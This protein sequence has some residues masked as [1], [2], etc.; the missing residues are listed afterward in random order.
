MPHHNFYETLGLDRTKDAPALAKEIDSRLSAG[1]LSAAARDELQVARK[2]LGDG[3][4]RQV[5]DAKL[6]DPN[7][8]EIT[9]SALRELAAADFG[10]Q[11]GAQQWRDVGDTVQMGESK[12]VEIDSD[13]KRT[14]ESSPKKNKPK[15]YFPDTDPNAEAVTPHPYPQQAAQPAYPP[16]YPA[17]YPYPPQGYYPPPQQPFYPPQ[18]APA[19]P[20]KKKSGTSAALIVAIV[21]ALAGIG[22]GG[23]WLWDNHGTEWESNDQ[24]LA[25]AFPQIVSEK[26][27]QRG[28]FDMKCQSMPLEAGQKARIRCSNN[29]LGVS[30]MDYGSQGTRDTMLPD[31]D[32]SVIGN[33]TCKAK[34]Y[35]MQDVSPPAFK[36]APEGPDSRFLLVVNGNDAEAKRMYLNLCDKNRE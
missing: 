33:S 6:G 34:S 30:V 28:W 1:N 15:Q 19:E 24:V 29:E 12:T 17:P 8:P 14:P 36:I 27:G 31:T 18:P 16:S 23:W 35:K 4:R 26:E 20:A 10:P 2:V 5:Y 21:L 22:A 13:T 25:D 9:V 32:A 7:A 3:R 11:P